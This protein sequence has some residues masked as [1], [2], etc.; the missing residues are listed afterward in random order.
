[1]TRVSDTHIDTGHR[2]RLPAPKTVK[3]AHP[4]STRLER[5]VYAHRKVIA[6]ILRRR[7]KRMIAIV[8]PC[9][10]HDPK[11]ALEYARQLAK[12]SEEVSDQILV[13]MRLYYQKPRTTT[14][15][16]GL[17]YDP[18]FSMNGGDVK[19]GADIVRDLTRSIVELGLPV[20]TEVLDQWMIQYIDDLVSWCCIGARTVESQPHRELAS[21]LSA[22]VGMKNTTDGQTRGAI[23]AVKAAN[24]SHSFFGMDEDGHLAIFP[25]R[26]NP[27]AHI[28]LRGGID[29]EGKGFSNY[30]S[31][32][33]G[34]T[35]AA[36]ESQKLL[37]SIIVDAAH[38]NMT[39]SA[40][41]KKDFRRQRDVV[42]DVLEQRL[43]GNTHIVGFMLESNLVEG[44]QKMPVNGDLSALTYGQSLTD[45]CISI[46]ETE[47]L[48]RNAAAQLRSQRA[49][50]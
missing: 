8:G 49:S 43:A 20:A 19:R 42:L 11:A 27:D 13:V 38:E 37:S 5:Q 46:R 10:I 6:D 50:A 39:D 2:T 16:K 22:P 12:L 23:N 45:P 34:S 4:A 36:L 44:N 1:M 3:A 30:D 40:T 33:I 18:G 31:T 7:D 17:F 15:W 26:G 35:V 28:V 24:H 21:G 14:G 48:L 25:T 41:G 29:G 9:S 32:T 47:R